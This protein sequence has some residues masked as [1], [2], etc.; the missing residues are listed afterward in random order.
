MT[1]IEAITQ[2]TIQNKIFTIRGKQVMIDRDLAV[3][4]GVETKQLKRQVKRNMDRFPNDEFM[5][6]LTTEEYN[7]LRS[8]FGTLK[9]GEHVKYL[10]QVFGERGVLMLSS[11]LRSES[12]VNVSIKIMTAFVEM[13]QL[14]KG[15]ADLYLR[16]NNVERK[17]VRTDENVEKIINALQSKELNP[18]Q[19]IFYDGQVFDAYSF[20]SD[21]VREAKTSIVLIDNYV[22]D[23]V[24]RLFAKRKQGVSLTIYTKKDAILNLD[25]VKYKAL[26]F[27]RG[28]K[29]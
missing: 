17:Q 12:S 15:H 8:Q 25:I 10:P 26:Y 3:L 5:F 13:R 23:T 27:Q 2:E 4:Y 7:S 28:H 20:I 16:L 22:D 29:L 19:G 11:I 1:A 24:L 9:R 18:K 21:L 14:L 6:E